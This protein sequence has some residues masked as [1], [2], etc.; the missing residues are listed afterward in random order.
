M[1]VWGAEE[2]I[3][4]SSSV[5][6]DVLAAMPIA[7]GSFAGRGVEI[8]ALVRGGKA[9]AALN[10]TAARMCSEDLSLLFFPQLFHRV[11]EI[12]HFDKF[13]T[14]GTGAWCR[15]VHRHVVLHAL[16][17]GLAVI[18]PGAVLGVFPAFQGEGRL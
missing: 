1:A 3:E 15:S 2:C 13:E 12:A 16:D 11:I 14:S 8:N 5:D 10:L 17:I 9:G 18:G 6:A 4:R 7:S